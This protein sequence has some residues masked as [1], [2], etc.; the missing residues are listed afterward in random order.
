MPN[1]RTAGADQFVEELILTVRGRRVI[2]AGDLAG[3]YGVDAKR[4]NEQVRRS[5]DRFPADFVFRLAREEFELL[6]TRGAISADGRVALR[7]QNATL[8]RGQLVKY[9][10][11][12]FTEHG[13]IMAA[14]VL[15][16]PRAVSMS[17]IRT[18][19][20]PCEVACRTGS[21]GSSSDASAIRTPGSC[22]AG[23]PIRAMPPS[24][25]H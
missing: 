19:K 5:S 11:Y 23:L 15:S 3:I 6:R 24:C 12:A 2:L 25:N 18:P 22:C 9:P 7:S 4:L 17:V 20:S 16:S 13:A 8:K 1:A 21:A 14:M 10:P